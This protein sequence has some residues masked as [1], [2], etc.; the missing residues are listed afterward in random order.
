MKLYRK[1]K[2]YR[3][4]LTATVEEIGKHSNAIVTFIY[5]SRQQKAIYLFGRRIK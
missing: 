5:Y 3:I 1:I 4:T 2:D